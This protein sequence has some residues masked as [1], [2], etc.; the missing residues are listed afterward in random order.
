MKN[1]PEFADVLPRRS[2]GPDALVQKGVKLTMKAG[3]AIYVIGLDGRVNGRAR[4]VAC[5]LDIGILIY[6]LSYLGTTYVM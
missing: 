1:V 5:L 2:T 3:A 6:S 4:C